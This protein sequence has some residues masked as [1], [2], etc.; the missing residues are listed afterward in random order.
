MTRY[1]H[2]FS[3]WLDDSSLS[4]VELEDLRKRAWHE[5]G[6]LIVDPSDPKLLKKETFTLFDIGIRLYGNRPL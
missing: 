5:Q 3:D 6:L 2:S 1:R 4:E